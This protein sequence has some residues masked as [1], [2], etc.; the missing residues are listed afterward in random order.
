M[1]Y[2]ITKTVIAMPR[3]I[4]SGEDEKFASDTIPIHSYHAN[5][6]N[7]EQYH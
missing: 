3:A 6:G 7:G 1:T 2:R 4:H 5:K